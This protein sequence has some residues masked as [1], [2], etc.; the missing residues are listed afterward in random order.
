LRHEQPGS[1]ETDLELVSVEPG[2]EAQFARAQPGSRASQA[3]QTQ[4]LQPGSAAR[5][6]GHGGK[7]ALNVQ[8]AIKWMRMTTAVSLS[9]NLWSS[10]GPISVWNM[11]DRCCYIRIHCGK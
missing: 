7:H 11:S 1:Q 2:W 6:L 8:F 5:V 4:E 3:T 9:A 10:V